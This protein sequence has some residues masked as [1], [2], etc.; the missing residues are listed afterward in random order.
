MFSNLFLLLIW[1]KNLNGGQSEFWNIG[2]PFSFVL[3]DTVME[4]HLVC[5][6]EFDSLDYWDKVN[7][8]LWTLQTAVWTIVLIFLLFIVVSWLH[9]ILLRDRRGKFLRSWWSMFHSLWAVTWL[10]TWLV[11]SPPLHPP[12]FNSFCFSLDT[13]IK[14]YIHEWE[15]ICKTRVG[16]GRSPFSDV[17][18]FSLPGFQ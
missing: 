3:K 15:F 17:V 10:D 11:Y 1:I 7:D 9:W 5:F 6:I 18:C 16:M 4:I 12:T 14:A 8:V 2:Y 13:V